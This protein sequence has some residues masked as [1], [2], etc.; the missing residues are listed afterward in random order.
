MSRFNRFW[1]LLLAGSAVLLLFSCTKDNLASKQEG[2]TE[3]TESGF[4]TEK[5]ALDIAAT[6]MESD[7]IAPDLRASS[8]PELSVIYTDAQ[9][10][11]MKS[12]ANSNQKPTYYVIDV[13]K[14]GF[15]IVSASDATYPVLGYSTESAFNPKDIPTNMQDMLSDYSKEIKYAWKH[16][17]S[18]EKTE[19]MRSSILSR[20][21]RNSQDTIVVAPLLGSIKWAQDPY[22]NDYCPKGCPV[23]C[24]ATAVAQ[25]MRYWEYPR[26]GTG[27]HSYKHK[28]YGTQSFNYEYNIDWKSMPKATLSEADSLVAKFCYGVAVGL[29][30]EFSPRGSGALPEDIPNMLKTYY[31]YPSTVQIAYRSQ[32][33]VKDWHKLVRKEL[34][35]RRPVQYSG[36]GSRGGHAFV[37]DGY[38]KNNYYHMNWGWGGTSD[39][40]F[41]LNALNPSDLGTGGGAGGFNARQSI[42]VGFAPRR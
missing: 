36:H 26:S 31:K 17:K 23:G 25:I 15:V 18:N 8:K 39:G 22:Y 32:Y 11:G 33:E 37:C 38:T 42:I 10:S 13:N 19:A 3:P 1:R 2:T 6:F 24:A 41:L 7:N 5:Q 35:A 14:K 21:T 4:V 29:D 12:S 28:V 9:G 40:Y 34:D 27:S 20:R 16:I 30:M